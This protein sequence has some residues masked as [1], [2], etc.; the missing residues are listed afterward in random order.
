M[1]AHPGMKRLILMLLALGGVLRVG[2]AFQIA[3]ARVMDETSVVDE[4]RDVGPFTGLAV[5][6]GIRAR[7]DAGPMS[8][9]VL[10]GDEDVLRH[11][12]V[13][14]ERGVAKVGFEPDYH[15]QI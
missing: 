1:G 10:R 2:T 8:G 11:V 7:I 13:V 6:A 9:I 14:V 4:T 12:R 5:S 15:G 3:E